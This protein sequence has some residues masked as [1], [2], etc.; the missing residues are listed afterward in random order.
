MSVVRGF[1]LNG[2]STYTNVTKPQDVSLTFTVTPTN[3][4]GVTSVK[5]NGYVRNVFMHTSTT[6]TS[7][8]GYLNPNPA[9][10]YCW[11]Q[12]TN[13]FNYFLGGFA[14]LT[15]ATATSTKIDNSVLVIGQAYVIT[16]VGNASLATWQ[17]VGVP[18]GVTPAVGVSFI[19]ITVG[20]GGNALTS[21]VQV[22][23][24][25][26]VAVVETVGDPA[27]MI[28][29]SS[30]ATNGGAWVMVQFLASALTPVAPAAGTVI[31][32]TFKFDGSSVTIDGL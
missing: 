32:M 7:N 26:A 22:P 9:N 27:T 12:F 30:I 11:V 24:S 3:G 15:A 10:G 18:P 2:K 14:R 31:T 23:T 17:A 21:R 13:N 6:P 16:V 8:D 29:N 19:A 5:S 1:G 20:A 28:A 4:L 25:S